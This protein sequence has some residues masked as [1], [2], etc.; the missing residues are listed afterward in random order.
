MIPRQSA[1]LSL[2]LLGNT[3]S[4]RRQH[5]R[6]GSILEAGVG[7]FF[8]P[9]NSSATKINSTALEPDYSSL[10]G[11]GERNQRCERSRNKQ[12]NKIV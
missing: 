12:K 10:A 8:F 9:P 2:P 4:K 7:F 6:P 5:D 3:S 1:G 11:E